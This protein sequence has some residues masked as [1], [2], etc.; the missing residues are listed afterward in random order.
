MAEEP[1]LNPQ[2]QVPGGSWRKAEWEVAGT[3]AVLSIT[4]LCV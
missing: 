1:V 4:G 2:L 3:P